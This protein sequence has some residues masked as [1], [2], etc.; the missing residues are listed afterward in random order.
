MLAR[1]AKALSRRPVNSPG[2][3][4][5]IPVMR[6]HLPGADMLLPYLRRIDENRNYSNWG[7]L[8]TE[9]EH[10]IAGAFGT[11]DADCI[12]SANSGTLALMGAVLAVAGRNSRNKPYAIIPAF[13]FVATA[14][15]I[16][17]SGYELP[18]R[19]RSAIM[20]ARSGATRGTS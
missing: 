13:T 17:Q 7:P 4:E 20:D 3:V 9:F 1:M 2:D 19:R 10:R 5:S 18:C 8:A 11:P 12:V 6:P 16:E 15:A 14:S